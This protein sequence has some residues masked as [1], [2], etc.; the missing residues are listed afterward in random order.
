MTGLGKFL[1]GLGLT[2]MAAA[3]AY[4]G[5]ATDAAPLGGA[6]APSATATTFWAFVA[7]TLMAIAGGIVSAKP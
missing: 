1:V 6:E 2:V 3:I 4:Y 7:G 5:I